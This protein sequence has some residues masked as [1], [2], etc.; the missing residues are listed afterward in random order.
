V[1]RR[2]F[3]TLLS[4][5]AEWPLAARAQQSA[6]PVVGFLNGGSPDLFANLVRALT[7]INMS[8][9]LVALSAQKSRLVLSQ[10]EKRCP[11]NKPTRPA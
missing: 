11:I 6:I 4:G 1:R 10:E 8:G 9:A 3:V 5:A 2:D 7:Q